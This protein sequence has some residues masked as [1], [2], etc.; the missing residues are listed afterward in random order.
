M[1]PS[2]R[3]YVPTPQYHSS[4]NNKTGLYIF[5]KFF[6]KSKVVPLDEIDIR[7]E[8][9]QIE[10]EKAQGLYLTSDQMG[11]SWWRRTLHWI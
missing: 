8:F 5:F 3:W 9:E 4:A 6:L 11:W 7:G 2:L 10:K 1:T